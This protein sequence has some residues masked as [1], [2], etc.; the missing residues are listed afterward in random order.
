MTESSQAIKDWLL[1][2][3]EREGNR[4][5]LRSGYILTIR[6]RKVLAAA[7]GYTAHF[8]WHIPSVLTDRAKPVHN[9]QMVDLG[10]GLN[11][12]AARDWPNM[13]N[14]FANL[15]EL[16]DFVTPIR[17][18]TADFLR[19]TEQI[20]KAGVGGSK[21]ESAAVKLTFQ[22]MALHVSCKSPPINQLVPTEFDLMPSSFKMH[23]QS[24]YLLDAA[25]I[26]RQARWLNLY[27][28]SDMN[29]LGMGT[30]GDKFAVVMGMLMN[31]HE[32]QANAVRR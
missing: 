6:G 20:R 27:I 17:V 31:E 32:E 30:V 4:L 9:F 3:T 8:S 11:L 5:D 22:E 18:K 2:A 19:V 15:I 13:E 24:G 10:R 21:T 12:N 28:K 26:F 1:K 16:F 23:T 14:G 7:S 29:M 25:S